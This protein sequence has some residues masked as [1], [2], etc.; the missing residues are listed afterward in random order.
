MNTKS[1][2]LR[3]KARRLT[4][5]AEESFE[6]SDTDGFLSQWAN[7]LS[8]RKALVEAEIEDAGGLGKIACIVDADDRI[9]PVRPIE[10]KFGQKF[11]RFEDFQAAND[12]GG[13]VVE[14]LT[15]SRLE[16]AGYRRA[17]CLR[18]AKAEIVGSDAATCYPM[19][20]PSDDLLIDP[21]A[22]VVVV[23]EKDAEGEIVEREVAR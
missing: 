12:R 20:V 2:E 7:N 23:F 15:A 14:W 11:A 18:P 22:R 19:A 5:K 8:A 6:R 9:A 1:E 4:E 13:Q 21:E 16:K 10:T 17:F 3:E